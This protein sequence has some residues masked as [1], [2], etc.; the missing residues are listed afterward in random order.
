MANKFSLRCNNEFR[1]SGAVNKEAGADKIGKVRPPIRKITL[2]IGE[3]NALKCTRP[4]SLRNRPNI[5]IPSFT[6]SK[7]KILVIMDSRY[8]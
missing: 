7:M 2:T 6:F 4:A 5:A 1:V 8:P 3:T